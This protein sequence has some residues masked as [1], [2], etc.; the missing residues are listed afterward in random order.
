MAL[1][2]CDVV[3]TDQIEVLPLLM[4][5]VER[6]TSRILQM[7]PGSGELCNLYVISIGLY[8]L[9]I[10]YDISLSFFLL[11]THNLIGSVNFCATQ[12]YLG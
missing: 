3:A 2:G 1:L 12:V 11:F 6:N 8:I 9:Q 4:R 5:N 10:L 7:N